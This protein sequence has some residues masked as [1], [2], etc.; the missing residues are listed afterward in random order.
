MSSQLFDTIMNDIKQAMKSQDKETLVTLRTLHS[1]IKNVAINKRKDITDEDVA[2]VVAKGIKQREDAIEQFRQ[3][4]R[5]DLID[6]EQAQIA[7]YKKYQPQQLNRDEIETLVE[8]V[9]SETGASAPK[10][11]GMVMKSLMPHVKGKA[12]GKVVNEIVNK[13]LAAR[14]P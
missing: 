13:K 6:K 9:I 8:N 2:L 10:D 7:V 3:G 14:A 5:S 4:G 11:M 12:D 1:E